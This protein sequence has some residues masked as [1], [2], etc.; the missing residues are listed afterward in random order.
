MH[1][2]SYKDITMQP[3]A[4][5]AANRLTR[6]LS[7]GATI[8]TRMLA[9]EKPRQMLLALLML[10]KIYKLDLISCVF[11]TFYICKQCQTFQC[12]LKYYFIKKEHD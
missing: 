2:G 6:V 3:T 5:T 1:N 12:H 4:T 11:A 9:C 7:P 8:C 10:A